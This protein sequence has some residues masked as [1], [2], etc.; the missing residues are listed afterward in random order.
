MSNV[1]EKCIIYG[2]GEWGRHAYWEYLD[3]YEIICYVDRN[4]QRWGTLIYGV[5]IKP[6]EE[7]ARHKEAVAIIA[8]D[9]DA[10]IEEYIR[11]FGTS[12]VEHYRYDALTARM[13]A[14]VY[15]TGEE[16]LA[17]A[18]AAG[19][20]YKISYLVGNKAAGESVDGLTVASPDFLRECSEAVLIVP[21]SLAD[22]ENLAKVHEIFAGDIITYSPGK[23]VWPILPVLDREKPRIF[24]DVTIS[25]KKKHGEGVARVADRLWEELKKIDN[26]ITPVRNMQGTLVTDFAY[27]GREDEDCQVSFVSGDRLLLLDPSW[28]DYSDFATIIARAQVAGA[29]V[30]AIVHDL[31]PAYLPEL[32]SESISRPFFFW[33]DMVL[34]AVED[35]ICN[36]DYTAKKAREYIQV[37]QLERS[38]PLEYHTIVLGSDLKIPA[39]LTVRR[40]LQ[41][42][43]DGAQV[44]LTVGTIEPR[45]GH[46]TIIKAWE[47]AKKTGSVKLL[48]MGHDG[49]LNHEIKQALHQYEGQGLF[50]LK[51]ATDEELAYAYKK[52]LALIEASLE[53]GFGLPLVEAGVY[54]LPVLC[55]DIDVFREVLGEKAMYFRKE[56]S[57]ALAKLMENALEIGREFLPV[58]EDSISWQET[59]AQLYKLLH[60]KGES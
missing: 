6:P 27:E 28:T 59:A 16:S 17:V 53:E 49:W 48:V 12:K 31:I 47:K 29:K 20:R 54:G 23:G 9:N 13:P 5:E 45:K 2:S 30:F 3:E 43:F 36:S 39:E 41:D 40:E 57:D 33:H 58:K 46:M 35:V 44:F 4:P 22:D 1:L 42:F 10:G 50:W 52:S 51:D 24:L 21:N 56:D 19:E 7:L 8:I 15:G 37:R 26:S 55:S 60:E 25:R 32:F 14:L 34:S 18:S 38:K 11:S